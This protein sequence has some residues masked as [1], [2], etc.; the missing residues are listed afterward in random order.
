M[1]HDFFL[2]KL[3]KDKNSKKLINFFLFR[4]NIFPGLLNSS[5]F[6]IIQQQQ[7]IV[8]SIV[9]SFNEKYFWLV[10]FKEK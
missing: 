8:Y 10:D 3:N 2:Q 7:D 1:C 5:I 4:F 6:F 9:I